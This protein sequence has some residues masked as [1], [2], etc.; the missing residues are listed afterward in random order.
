ME[1]A[2]LVLQFGVLGLGILQ[3]AVQILHELTQS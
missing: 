2:Q 1:I 3:A